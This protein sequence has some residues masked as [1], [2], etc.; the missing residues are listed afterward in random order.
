[1]KKVFLGICVVCATLVLESCYSSSLYYGNVTPK[2]PVK[3]VATEHHSHFIG[4]LIGE[5]KDRAKEHVNGA[6]DY[7]VKHQI[8][9]L[10]GLISYVTGGL[11]T[12]STTKYYVPKNSVK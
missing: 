5:G 6:E 8:T 11:Y 9:F 3:K 1:M 7:K 12:P 4:G 10:D 2:T